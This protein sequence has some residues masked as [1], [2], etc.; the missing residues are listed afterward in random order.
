MRIGSEAGHP[1]IPPMSRVDAHAPQRSSFAAALASADTGSSPTPDAGHAIDFT[2]A[3]RQEL[4]DWMNGQIL[5]G[6]MTL[7]ESTPFLGM[8]LK[9]SR[10]TGQ[11]VD[12][13]A[14]AAPVNFLEKASLGIEGALVRFDNAG[15]ERLRTA[16]ETIASPPTPVLRRWRRCITPRGAMAPV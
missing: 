3:T 11:H 16:L 15:A 7:D 6:R 1:W 10:A 2:R 5:S 8:T 14:D 9:F 12:I 13:A 4:F